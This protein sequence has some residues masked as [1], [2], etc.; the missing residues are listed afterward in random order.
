M[1]NVRSPWWIVVG[2][3]LGLVVGNGPVMQF[4]FGVFV[5]PVSQ[6]LHAERGTLSAA[7]MVG[8]LMTG[9]A[10]PLAG[11][12]VDRFGIRAVAL[13]A[14]TLFALAMAG[15]GL[16]ADATWAFVALYGLAGIVAA[17]QTP[18]TYCK[19]VSSAFDARRGLALGISIA[20]VG[21]GTALVPLFA[22]RVLAEFGWRAAYVGLGA[23]TLVIA[24]PAMAFLVARRDATAGT[25]R[26]NAAASLPGLTAAQAVRSQAFWKLALSFFLVAL[27]ASGTIAHIVPMMVDRGMEARSATA[28]LS[29][30]G[31]AL[32]GGRLL[33]G[34]L[35]DRVF[36]PFIAVVFFALP[37]V[38][39]G[40]LLGS[41]A[42]ALTVPAAV[43]VG[44][45]L[46]A[47]VDLIAFL[48]SRYLGLRA[49]GEIYG[50]LFA[51][52]MLGSAMGPFLMGMSYQ[53]LHDYAPAMWLLM[54][55]LLVAIF[56]MF[57]LGSYLFG[58][59]PRARGQ[60]TSPDARAAH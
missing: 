55:G 25:A 9:V 26:A 28:A 4:S 43:L 12:L 45:G 38:G 14:I 16:F 8:L 20:G 5:M 42:T 48:Q 11:R 30:A 41:S 22:Q 31:I 13:P 34:Y 56:L 32:I 52:F 51:V 6:A 18:L 1:K 59:A 27:A 54:A 60:V 33:A 53:H 35:L 7:L 3:V 23:L 36:A 10:T 49:F 24:L 29:A 40:M 2:S 19:A 50:Y 44:L 21:L 57:R 15:I 17:G 58:A 47:E 46:G 37:L 39:I